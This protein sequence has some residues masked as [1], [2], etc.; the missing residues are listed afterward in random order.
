[1]EQLFAWSKSKLR[2]DQNAWQNAGSCSHLAYTIL[3]AAYIKENLILRYK[4]LLLAEGLV[5][6]TRQHFELQY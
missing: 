1:M 3:T 6:R 5:Q 2:S 4:A